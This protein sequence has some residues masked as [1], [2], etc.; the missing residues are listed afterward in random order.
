M[1]LQICSKGNYG[2]VSLD[3]SLV[4]SQ[5]V[6]T[7]VMLKGSLFQ[8]PLDSYTSLAKVFPI[9]GQLF[10]QPSHLTTAAPFIEVTFFEEL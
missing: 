6:L 8:L 9:E 7:W 4:A 3:I 10:I 2:F 1:W 5:I